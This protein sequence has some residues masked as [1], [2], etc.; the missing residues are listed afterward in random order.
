M[1]ADQ[2]TRRGDAAQESEEM[3]LPGDAALARQQ[4][5]QHAAVQ[6][7]GDNPERLHSEAA[8]AHLCG[9][10]PIPASS[11]KSNR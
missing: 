7:A 9:V 8:W 11:G 5:P 1:A 10:A 3:A 6:D 4:A 2:K